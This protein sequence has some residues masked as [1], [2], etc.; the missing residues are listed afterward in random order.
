M[1]DPYPDRARYIKD[2][3]SPARLRSPPV[4]MPTR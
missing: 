1:T 3:Q 2:R 4:R